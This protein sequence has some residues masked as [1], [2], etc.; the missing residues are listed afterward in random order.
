VTVA[1]IPPGDPRC[2]QGGAA[3]TSPSG[4]SYLCNGTPGPTGP[5]GAPGPAG[6]RWRDANGNLV[7]GLYRPAWAIN[8]L[9]YAETYYQDENEVIWVLDQSTNMLTGFGSLNPATTDRYYSS[10]DC[11]G[12]EL[13]AP[14]GEL[15]T[16]GYAYGG[17][18]LF[19]NFNIYPTQRLVCSWFNSPGPPSCS[20]VQCEPR[21][22]I[23][24]T[25]LQALVPLNV[26]TFPYQPPFAPL[27]R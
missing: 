8:S 9:G 24:I 20:P 7:P 23:L 5:T 2:P 13:Y 18:G 16:P 6:V 15:P 10:G 22:S 26:P 11:T 25:E 4:G 14:G 3:F 19:F 12:T 17:G 1:V 27:L 21:P